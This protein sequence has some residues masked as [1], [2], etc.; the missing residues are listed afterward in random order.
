[1]STFK[2]TVYGV[3]RSVMGH[4]VVENSDKDE[5]MYIATQMLLAD[6][7]DLKD[8]VTIETEDKVYSKYIFCIQVYSELLDKEYYVDGCLL[9]D[10]P[11]R[12]RNF[13]QIHANAIINETDNKRLKVKLMGVSIQ[14][15]LEVVI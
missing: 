1:M 5:A 2:L 7:I 15:I 13:A 12:A 4:Y 11:Q 3:C 9:A 14:P 10:E 8:V 6:G